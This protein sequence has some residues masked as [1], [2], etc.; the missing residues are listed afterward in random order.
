MLCLAMLC[1]ER[2]RRRPALHWRR[3][4]AILELFIGTT[5]TSKPT[6]SWLCWYMYVVCVCL[7]GTHP[8]TARPP[9]DGRR[10]ASRTAAPRWRPGRYP[11]RTAWR[12]GRNPPRPNVCT[13]HKD[14]RSEHLHSTARHRVCGGR[15]DPRCRPFRRT[16]RL[17]VRPTIEPTQQQPS[18]GSSHCDSVL[19]NSCMALLAKRAGVGGRSEAS[20][21]NRGQGEDP[22]DDSRRTIM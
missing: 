17:Q 11:G 5:H 18:G 1:H 2:H 3:G 6:R 4:L 16:F 22:S 8:P 7:C 9:Q 19:G 12:C 20:A 10:R 14:T 13:A 15:P 21:V